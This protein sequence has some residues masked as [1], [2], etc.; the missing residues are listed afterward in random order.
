MMWTEDTGIDVTAA[1]VG[2][3]TPVL[4]LY[5]EIG[6]RGWSVSKTGI[7]NGSFFCQAK[8]PNGESIEKVGPDENTAAG[9]VLLAIMRQETMRHTKSASWSQD[10]KDELPQIAQSYAKAPAYEPKAAAAWKELADDMVSR[11]DAISDQIDVEY[12]DDPVPYKDINEMCDDVRNK[13]HISIS[14][15]NAEHPV[16]NR[17]QVLAYRLCRD[18]LGH[19]QAGGDYGWLGENR[20]TAAMMPLLSPNAQKAL[21][22]ESIGQAAYNNYYKGLG[23]QKIT[24]LDDHVEPLQDSE[25]D[26][27]HWGVHPSQSLVP[28]QIPVTSSLSSGLA[29]P[30]DGWDSGVSPLPDNAY[31]WQR[32]QI[33]GLD[34]LDWQGTR[35]K[36]AGIDTDWHHLKNPDGDD[37]DTQR[38]AVVNALRAA[39]M[40][41]RKPMESA[42]T[43][44]QHISNIPARVSDPIRF[45]NTLETRRDNHNQAAGLEPGVHRFGWAPE[46]RLF[47]QWVQAAEP[48]K[49]PDQIDVIAQK[50]LFHMLAEEEQRIANEDEKGNMTSDEIEAKAHKA[51][52]KRLKMMT[53]PSINEKTDHKDTDL[54]HAA[55]A[56]LGSKPYFPYL[57]NQ[58]KAIAG[59]GRHADDILDAAHKDVK[60]HK[61]KGHHFRK[62]I[63]SLGIPNVGA[64]EAS[65]A[66]L[67]LQPQTSELGVIDPHVAKALG[68]KDDMNERDYFK[69]E[70]QLATGRDAAGY[71]HV[72]LGQFGWGLHDHKRGGHGHHRDLRP[73]RALDPQPYDESNWGDV[74]EQDGKWKSP[75]WWDST[76]AARED[77]GK[78]W[79][80]EVGSLHPSKEVPF[81]KVAYKG[82]G[83]TKSFAHWWD[84][85]K[86]INPSK[87]NIL[88]EY[89]VGEKMTKKQLNAFL[90]DHKEDVTDYAEFKKK[91][92]EKAKTFPPYLKDSANGRTPVFTNESGKEVAGTPGHTLMQHI[93]HQ[94]ALTTE[95]IWK[96]I[97]D[98][99]KR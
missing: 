81:Q 52:R 72:P 26:T 76:K 42:A 68:R 63:L 79:D 31:L 73:M 38:Q 22:T 65:H 27:T 46:E 88:A 69:L 92:M 47:K 86:P 35:D 40:S 23:A 17:K 83:A 75:Y 54:L 62:H 49:T 84:K 36:A 99:A 77:I 51:I 94:T 11:S 1:F 28:S 34:P 70:R 18:V 33:T 19:C 48:D 41:P 97:S 93:K 29:D 37:L 60:E 71:G 8:S 25:N 53:K 50:Q 5:T 64:R 9:H 2:I 20:A 87:A 24:L 6:K 58:V 95:E 80:D 78:Q 85:E 57:A 98:A 7:K 16:W 10:W 56:Q 32:D 3:T 61:G 90:K 74:A 30:N 91:I 66:W 14:R 89:A 12:V 39:T 55:S 96:Q 4:E 67:M 45:W 82:W 59:I 15:A 43:H 44:Y 21:F 13:R